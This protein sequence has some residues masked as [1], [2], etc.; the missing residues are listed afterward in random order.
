[1]K[2]DNQSQD[3]NN[4]SS[5]ERLSSK[6]SLPKTVA[7]SF[8][9]IGLMAFALG[10][11][12]FITSKNIKNTEDK[13]LRLQILNI[14]LLNGDKNVTD[15][16]SRK[17]IE[18]EWYDIP[19]N[20]PPEL[21]EFLLQL[22]T[23]VHNEELRP[24][25]EYVKLVDQNLNRLEFEVN[26]LYSEKN[27][28]EARAIISGDDYAYWKVEFSNSIEQI[29]SI[30]SNE[31]SI[32]LEK[33]HDQTNYAISMLFI[34]L[35]ILLTSYK[36]IR[37]FSKESAHLTS[38]LFSINEQFELAVQGSQDGLWDWRDVNDNKVWWSPRL[39]D[40]LG[41][42][43]GEIESSRSSFQKLLHPDDIDKWGKA[44]RLH[45]EEQ[46]LYDIEQRLRIKSGEYRWFNARAQAIWDE[47]GKP[48]R[49]AGSIRDIHDQKM[50]EEELRLQ[51]EIIKNMSEGVAL[52]RASDSSIVYTNPRFEE[53]FG[54]DTGELIGKHISV[55]NNPAE[56]SPQEISKNI[57]SSVNNQGYW[58][59]D[60]NKIKK[61][62]TPFWVYGSIVSFDQPM[63]GQVFIAVYTDITELRKA[64][65]A[66]RE[67]E[68][69]LRTIIEKTPAMFYSINKNGEI[70]HA[71]NFW[72]DTMGYTLEEVLGKKS[73]S[74]LTEKSKNFAEKKALPKF[75]IEGFAIDVPY[76]YVKKNEEILDMKLSAYA[77][78]NESGE[79]IRSYAVLTA[80][81]RMFINT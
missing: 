10:I 64:E 61:N 41:Y 26:K 49:M 77:D 15:T 16:I 65:E 13:I 42:E 2:R 67:S 4:S 48:K 35:P 53:V 11:Y 60:I 34:L 55:T 51:S 37:K 18:E 31:L 30:T 72:L 12:L 3:L 19:I 76:Q 47:N 23:Y 39:Y 20:K 36:I 62:G 1:M 25:L 59:G 68:K 46:V 33:L 8:V 57:V 69:T 32:L 44:T 6:D 45:L 50:T 63:Y 21:P 28:S 66:L 71:S 74:F 43:A 9:V 7:I 38:D 58:K 56:R 24:I 81:S 79:F 52:I 27:L 54:Y 78:M 5:G 17:L 80:F 14:S 73:T 70:V 29:F 75:F 40:L 22:Y